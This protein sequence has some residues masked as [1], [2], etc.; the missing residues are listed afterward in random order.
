MAD[1]DRA[2]GRIDER[3]QDQPQVDRAD[4]KRDR[5]EGDREREVAGR[6]AG[7]R[8]RAEPDGLQPEVDEDR[9]RHRDGD[10]RDR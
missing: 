8:T 1:A 3:A 9:E 6:V 10:D 5:E 7:R 2:L 4:G